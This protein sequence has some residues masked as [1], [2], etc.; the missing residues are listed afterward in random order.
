MGAASAR[1]ALSWPIRP[2]PWRVP[3]PMAA[4]LARLRRRASAVRARGARVADTPRLSSSAPLVPAMQRHGERRNAIASSKVKS[5][6]RSLSMHSCANGLGLIGAL[7]IDTHRSRH[8]N[9][10]MWYSLL[11]PAARKDPQDGERF[12]FAPMPT[13]SAP[14]IA[15]SLKAASAESC[16]KTPAHQRP[17]NGKPQ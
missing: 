12:R 1:K 5:R 8:L 15:Q 13:S 16:K 17:A 11:K 7:S 2:A 9:P 10:R 4:A 14:R 6:R 3:L